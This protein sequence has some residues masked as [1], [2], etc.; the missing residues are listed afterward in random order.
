LAKSLV[1]EGKAIGKGRG[2]KTGEPVL[3]KEFAERK[4]EG[5]AEMQAYVLELDREGDRAET[6]P[7]RAGQPERAA[8]KW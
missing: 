5:K 6:R 3:L 1:R 7:A 4:L 2:S 8:S